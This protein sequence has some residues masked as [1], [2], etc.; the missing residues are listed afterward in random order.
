MLDLQGAFV[1]PGL[2]NAHARLGADPFRGMAPSSGDHPPLEAV[3]DEPSVIWSC[4][5]DGIAAAR[6]G[7]TCVI[8]LHSSPRFVDDAVHRV[9]EVLLTIGLRSVLAYEVGPSEDD[10]AVETTRKMAAYGGTDQV[11]MAVGLASPEFLDKQRLKE[12]AEI[13]ARYSSPVHV[14]L[15]SA[16]GGGDTKRRRGSI[17][18]MMQDSGL[19]GPDT[20]LAVGPELAEDDLAACAEAGATL[21]HSPG[22]DVGKT[23]RSSPLAGFERNAALGTGRGVPDVL[24]EA[25]VL[26]RLSE[27]A[28]EPAGASRLLE[29][30]AG[31]HRLATRIFGKPFGVFEPGASADL[32]VLDYVPAIP[33]NDETVAHHLFHGIE[34]RHIS[35]VMVQGRFV[36]RDGV[37]TNLDEPRLLAQT[38]RGALDLWERWTGE[39]FPGYSPPAEEEKTIARESEESSEPDEGEDLPAPEEEEHEDAPEGDAEEEEA[40]A[41]RSGPDDPFGAGLF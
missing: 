23:T 33:L 5:V 9:R 14:E 6:T 22:S 26:M 21:V 39:T 18:K 37:F 35:S 38:R 1:M 8:D 4:F 31:G 36:I 13:V 29:L 15:G 32:V 16:A 2:V 12:I 20:I 10:E 30:L 3:H 7:T 11:R 17:M 34:A 19:L 28:G 41:T 40:G 24:A 27:A 25:R